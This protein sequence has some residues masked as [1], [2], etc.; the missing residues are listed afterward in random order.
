LAQPVGGEDSDITVG[1]TLRDEG[2]L[3]DQIAEEHLLA[4]QVRRALDE[5][6]AGFLPR[7][8]EVVRLRLFEGIPGPEVAAR[9]GVT[10]GR[11]QQIEDLALPR[12]RE[13]LVAHP[14]VLAM[15]GKDASDIADDGAGDPGALI[16]IAEVELQTGL[17]RDEV[18]DLIGH[19]KF[20]RSIDKNTKG[21]RLWSL[22]AVERWRPGR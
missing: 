8:K 15:L 19:G 9:M 12:L 1:D 17:S 3:P 20:P 7:H 18:T 16:G 10:R 22:S 5:A 4:Q 6:M 14:A 2:P 11:V 13:A 21:N